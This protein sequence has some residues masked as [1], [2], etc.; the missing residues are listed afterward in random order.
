MLAFNDSFYILSVM[1]I[2]IL[3]F[4]LLMKEAKEGIPPSGVH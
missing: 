1:M 4:V 2:L 3:P